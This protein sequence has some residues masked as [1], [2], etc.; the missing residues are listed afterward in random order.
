M[1]ALEGR[2]L[3]PTAQCPGARRCEFGLDLMM[4]SPFLLALVAFHHNQGAISVSSR[5][6]P[7]VE[8]VCMYG[9]RCVVVVVKHID[10][11]NPSPLPGLRAG[12]ELECCLI[13]HVIHE[14]YQIYS[15]SVI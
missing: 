1:G 7:K 13:L 9:T 6:E 10:Q 2:T 12:A 14:R 5:R 4:G 8:Q 3:S 15:D 11:R